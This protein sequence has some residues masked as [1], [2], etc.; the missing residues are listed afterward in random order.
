MPSLKANHRQIMAVST[1]TLF[2]AVS[3]MTIDGC[4]CH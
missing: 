3:T 1:I 4:R 2:D